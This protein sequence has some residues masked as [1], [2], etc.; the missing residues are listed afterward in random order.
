MDE[1]SRRAPANALFVR[2]AVESLPP[3][4]DGIACAVTVNFPWGSLFEGLLLPRAEVV[5]GVRVLM[6][7]GASL[8]LTASVDEVRDAALLSR[9]PSNVFSASHRQELSQAYCAAGFGRVSAVE[10]TVD[11]ARAA[12]TTWAK[13]L[14]AN[15]DR[16]YWRL[17]AIAR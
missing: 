17:T 7:E 2:A 6:R 1:A 11:E 15:A 3:E 12:G 16:T 4:L 13:K 8:T 10:L 9:F 14:S 5:A